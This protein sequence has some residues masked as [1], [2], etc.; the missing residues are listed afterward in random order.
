MGKVHLKVYYGVEDILE[1]YSEIKTLEKNVEY[2]LELLGDI[3][4][5]IHQQGEMLQTIED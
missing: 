3:E 4:S 1:K 2:I 5:L